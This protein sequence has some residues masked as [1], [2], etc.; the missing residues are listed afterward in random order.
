MEKLSRQTNTPSSLTG[1]RKSLG[2]FSA[3]SD[4]QLTDMELDRYTSTLRKEELP[5]SLQEIPD[6]QARRHP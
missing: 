5:R 4:G 3:C 1:L 2:R 6:L